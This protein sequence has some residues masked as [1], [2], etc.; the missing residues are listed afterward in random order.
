VDSAALVWYL[1][2]N[3]AWLQGC[4]LGLGLVLGGVAGGPIEKRDT[5]C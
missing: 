4:A 2:D 3:D 1:F 5:L